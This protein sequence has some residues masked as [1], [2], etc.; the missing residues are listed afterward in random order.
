MLV[1]TMQGEYNEVNQK[2]NSHISKETSLETEIASLKQQL[3]GANQ[4]LQETEKK[5]QDSQALLDEK[6]HSFS[7]LSFQAEQTLKKLKEKEQAEKRL[8]DEVEKLRKAGAA[9]EELSSA[10]ASLQQK[11]D[12]LLDKQ[13]A[14][15]LEL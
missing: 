13:K 4:G 8:K 6:N 10:K 2:L 11:Y 1:A 14:L 3:T 7:L 15:Q 5:L 12:D 9:F